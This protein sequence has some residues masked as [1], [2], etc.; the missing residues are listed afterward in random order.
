M[1]PRTTPKP[2]PAWKAK[3]WGRDFIRVKGTRCPHCGCEDILG[4]GV[5]VEAGRAWQNQGCENCDGT[6]TAWY[7]LTAVTPGV[8]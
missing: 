2:V 8:F 5:E 6:W 4:S 1:K 3:P 7:T